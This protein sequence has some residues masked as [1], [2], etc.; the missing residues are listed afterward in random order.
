MLVWDA[1]CL[2]LAAG[3]LVSGGIGAANASV[4]LSRAAAM[5][6]QGSPVD[7]VRPRERRGRSHAKYGLWFDRRDKR[8]RLAHALLR[9]PIASTSKS[10]LA[11]RVFPTHLHTKRIGFARREDCRQTI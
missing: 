9:I 1:Q 4:L 11:A 2:G 10:P 7:Q 3:D 5:F 6:V 8:D